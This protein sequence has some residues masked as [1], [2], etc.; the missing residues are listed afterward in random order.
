MT[1]LQLR[2]G[3][4]PLPVF[5]PDATRAVVR[6]VEAG[7]LEAVGVAGLVM[8]TFH[9]MQHPGSSVVASHGG[10]H[11]FSGWKRPI[12]TDSGGF[13]VYSLVRQNPKYGSLSEKGMVFRADDGEKYNLTPEKSIQLQMSYGGDVVYVLDDCTHAD[14]DEAT[15]VDS[16]RRT[17]KWAR[18]CREVY[19]D[20]VASKRMDEQTRPRLYGVV[21]GGNIASLRQECAQALLEIGFDGFGFGGYPLDGEHNLLAEMFEVVR[22]AIPAHYPLHALGVG[23]PA[24]VL[25]CAELGYTIFDSAL[26]T[27]DAR[28]GRLYRMIGEPRP[29]TDWFKFIYIED[30]KHTRTTEPIDTG[31]TCPACTRYSIAYMHHLHA[32]E[33]AAFIRLATLHNLRFMLR[34]MDA[35]RPAVPVQTQP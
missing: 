18:R 34:L 27:R 13:Q 28:R 31:C 10:L 26:P 12:V 25:A 8:S 17:I 35:L 3:V 33:D 14:A 21:Q 20:L 7:D 30:D 1:N 9:V 29:G 4:L 24:N 23:H 19:D 15:Q 32:I 16:V 5:L 2:H 22:A 6:G 11:P